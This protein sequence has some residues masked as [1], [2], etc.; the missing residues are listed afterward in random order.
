M[1]DE[2]TSP[3]WTKA[4]TL[5]SLRDQARSGRTPSAQ[6]FVDESVPPGDL[7]AKVKELVEGSGLAEIVKIGPIHRLARS[8]SVE[9]SVD[10]IERI[11]SSGAVK[12]VL[13]SQVDDIY[14]KAI[15]TPDR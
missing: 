13:P 2:N 5:E 9:G 1:S 12:A 3:Q 6:V 14:P 11:A 7:D 8:F 4:R 15:K 10:S